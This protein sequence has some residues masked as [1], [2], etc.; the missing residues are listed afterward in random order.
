MQAWRASAPTS[1]FASIVQKRGGEVPSGPLR[2]TPARS[3]LLDLGPL[4]DMRGTGGY[5]N[6]IQALPYWSLT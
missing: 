3:I 4:L 6:E 2:H 5:A 1:N